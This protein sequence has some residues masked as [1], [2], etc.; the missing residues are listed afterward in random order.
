VGGHKN[1][2]PWWVTMVG[3]GGGGGTGPEERPVVKRGLG[4]TGPKKKKG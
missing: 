2:V 1:F 3:W 4:V